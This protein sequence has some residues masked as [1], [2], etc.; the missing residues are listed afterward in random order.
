M[1]DFYAT[2]QMLHAEMLSIAEALKASIHDWPGMLLATLFHDIIYDP[3]SSENEELSAHYMLDFFEGC[4]ENT[5]FAD[6]LKHAAAAILCTKTHNTKGDSTIQHGVFGTVDN[7]AISES[8]AVLHDV[9]LLLD[10]D[11]A[12]LGAGQSRYAQYCGQVRE[13]FAH[14]TDTEFAVGR[15]QFLEGLLRSDDSSLP[16]FGNSNMRALY[17]DQAARNVAHEICCIKESAA[18]QGPSTC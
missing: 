6:T 11:M 9:Q 2:S 8:A 13:E 3:T 7:S 12:I 16:I 4:L 18:F 17:E 5:K 15:L 10:C 1:A 14:L